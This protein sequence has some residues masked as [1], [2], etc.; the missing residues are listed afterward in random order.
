MRTIQ[1][2]LIDGKDGDEYLKQLSFNR[3][4]ALDLES[5]FKESMRTF[6]LKYS[7]V[8]GKTV[9]SLRDSSIMD[10]FTVMNDFLCQFCHHLCKDEKCA[11]H[12][13]FFNRL[14]SKR[15]EDVNFS[16]QIDF[17]YLSSLVSK[18]NERL[19]ELIEQKTSRLFMRINVEPNNETKW[20]IA[21]IVYVLETD[22]SKN[23]FMLERLEALLKGEFKNQILDNIHKSFLQEQEDIKKSSD[24]FKEYVQNKYNIDVNSE[25]IRSAVKSL[26]DLLN[27]ETIKEVFNAIVYSLLYKKQ[28]NEYSRFIELLK[29][30]SIKLPF[31]KSGIISRNKYKDLMS[32]YL[33]IYEKKPFF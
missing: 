28:L 2:L 32:K 12:L 21:F 15:K 31:G 5:S 33:N 27:E 30:K 7:Y 20:M 17:E 23:E 25:G 6:P 22:S 4:I 8:Y 24:L 1:G 19:D 26:H 29:S 13:K 11:T 14:L 10:C 9:R 16:E 18:L 3:D